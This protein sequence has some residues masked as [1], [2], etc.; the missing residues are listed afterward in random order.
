MALYT[1][2]KSLLSNENDCTT[3]VAESS[4]SWSQILGLG[5]VRPR[6]ALRA[7]DS[8]L[9]GRF[10]T[11]LGR[12]K[13]HSGYLGAPA[14]SLQPA[15]GP[16]VGWVLK[17]GEPTTCMQGPPGTKDAFSCVV[18]KTKQR[19]KCNYEAFWDDR[20]AGKPVIRLICALSNYLTGALL[21]C[22]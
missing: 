6:E 15:C 21:S 8:T 7:Q 1:M 4:G 19:Q 11:L 12:G 18:T 2:M 14:R 22:L 10:E 5:V 9:V 17:L 20:V 13:G 16:S 3:S